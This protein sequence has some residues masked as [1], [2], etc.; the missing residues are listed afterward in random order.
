MNFATIDPVVNQEG[1]ELLESYGLY[2][3][4]PDAMDSSRLKDFVDCPS[5]FYLR[6]ILGLRPK[7][8][9]PDYTGKFDWGTCWHFVLEAYHRDSDDPSQGD[10]EKALATLEETYPEYLT[11]DIDK[12][13]RSKERMIKQLFAYH[14]KFQS[15]NAEYEIL[16][17]EQFFDYYSEEDDLRWCGRI[18]SI[19]RK[20]RGGTIRVWDYKTSSAMGSNYFPQHEL[21]FQFPGYVW[22]ANQMFTDE[23]LDITI[24]VMYTISRSFEFFRRTFRYDQYKRAEFVQNVKY[25]IKQIHYLCANHLYEPWA[26]GQNRNECTRYGKCLFFPVHDIHPKGETRLRILSNDYVSDRWEPSDVTF[27]GEDE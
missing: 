2:P 6:H 7:I 16:R 9:T 27:E 5:Q 18:D 25:W 12:Y 22:A 10:I 4:I 21:G 13:N 23:V 24:D 11:P 3:Q 26:W 8:L 19:R 20:I 14:E 17:H 15:A 1:K